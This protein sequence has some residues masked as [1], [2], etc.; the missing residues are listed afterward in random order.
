MALPTMLRN[1]ELTHR[2]TN[3]QARDRVEASRLGEMVPKPCPLPQARGESPAD[4]PI[5]RGAVALCTLKLSCQPCS[6]SPSGFLGEDSISF[7]LHH[8]LLSWLGLMEAGDSA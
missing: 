8:L 1:T 3:S 6:S 4:V 7:R 2:C 5:R